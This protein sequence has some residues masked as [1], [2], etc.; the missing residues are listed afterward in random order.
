MGT[1]LQE[2]GHDIVLYHFIDLVLKKR[3]KVAFYI[4]TPAV[5]P[6]R[7]IH[8]WNPSHNE[9]TSAWNTAKADYIPEFFYRMNLEKEDLERLDK[10]SKYREQTWYKRLSKKLNHDLKN[11]VQKLCFKLESQLKSELPDIVGI[12]ENGKVIL[13]AEIKFEGFGEKAKEEVLNEYQLAEQLHISYYLTFPKKPTYGRGLTNSWLKQHL[14]KKMKIYR[15]ILSSKSVIPKQT[16]IKFE[17]V[18]K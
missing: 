1:V 10:S 4:I 9:Y 14:P 17:E 3:H 15:F 13:M 7:D 16:T 8:Y 12:D 6:K 18:K 5:G 2:M 11:F